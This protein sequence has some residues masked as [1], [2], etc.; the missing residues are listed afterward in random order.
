M[1]RYMTSGDH[2]KAMPKLLDWCDEASTAHWLQDDASAL[3]WLEAD[4]RMRAEGRP[5]KVLYPSSNHRELTY[6]TPR[7]AG[8]LPIKPVTKA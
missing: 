4:R 1:R 6:R 8:N 2:I 5:S 7:T 3:E